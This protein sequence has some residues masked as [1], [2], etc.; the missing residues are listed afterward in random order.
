MKCKFHLSDG[1]TVSQ[2]PENYNRFYIQEYIEPEVASERFVYH[3]DG[4]FYWLDAHC[5]ELYDVFQRAIFETDEEFYKYYDL[6]PIGL[7]RAGLDSDVDLSKDMFENYFDDSLY[8]T[9]VLEKENCPAELK[10][11]YEGLDQR[12]YKYAYTA[13]CHGL[14][15]SLQEL[16]I[17]SNTSFCLF[18]KYLAS[19]RGAED[20]CNNY[21]T[22]SV[23]SR[24]TFNMLHSFIIQVYSMFD[25]LTK[26]TYELENIKECATQYER[27]AS[28]KILFGDKKNL[29]LDISDTIFET[30]RAISVFVNLRNELI[31]NSTWE[32][33]PKVFF[34]V[35]EG[36]ITER[37]IYLPDFGPDG[38]LITYK[39]RKR[40]FSEGKKVNHE[41]PELYMEVLR[42]V[43]VTITKL[44]GDNSLL[45]ESG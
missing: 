1:V 28:R 33:N 36:V 18:Y 27:M 39:N 16:I 2:L 14:I 6:Q 41:L 24:I 21:F 40:F 25:I 38:N 11:Y 22:M 44:I 34:A 37:C 12:K 31:H 29:K 10:L 5:V 42:R 32:M 13:D 26:L 17:G 4:I 9:L 30:C 7:M 35:N 15:N 20:F 19:V 23:D 43:R 3:G 8:N 45:M